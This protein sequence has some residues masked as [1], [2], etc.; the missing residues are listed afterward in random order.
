[1]RL[2]MMLQDDEGNV[3][4]EI[5]RTVAKDHAPRVT[6]WLREYFG[7]PKTTVKATKEG[8]SDT[9]EPVD[10]AH[11]F[12]LW[13]EQMLDRLRNQVREYEVRKQ[14]ASGNSLL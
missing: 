6:E 14:P 1:M 8:E 10:D 11:L 12:G 5:E 3:L 4:K 9:E 2:V 7:D 13:G